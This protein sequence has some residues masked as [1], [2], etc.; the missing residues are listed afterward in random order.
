MEMHRFYLE[1]EELTKKVEPEPPE[2]QPE[3]G[4]PEKKEPEDEPA[5]PF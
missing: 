1:L 5:I 4:G 3:P 2:P